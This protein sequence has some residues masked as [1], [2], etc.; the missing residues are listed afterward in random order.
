ME[1]YEKIELAQTCYACPEQYDVYLDKEIIGY[2]RLRHGYF[3]ADFMGEPVYGVYTKGYG[4][5]DDDEREEHLT[6][7][8][9]AIYKEF[10]K[11][12]LA[13]QT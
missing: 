9:K 7:A 3:R 8:K 6:N 11:Y 5:F 12:K 1:G 4:C 10:E 2:M 13:K